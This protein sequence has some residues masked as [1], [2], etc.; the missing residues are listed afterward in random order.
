MAQ[1][2]AVG[3]RTVDEAYGNYPAVKNESAASGVSWAAVAAGAFVTAAFS[4][5]L[6]ALGAGAGL[7]SLSPWGSSGVSPETVG[8][9]ALVWL[10]IVEI[11]AAALGGYVAGRLRTKWVDTHTDEV[12]FR[13]TAHGLLT[14]AVALVI[15]AAFLGSAATRMVGNESRAEG[16][17]ASGVGRSEGPAMEANRYYVDSLFRSS[18]PAAANEVALRT[19]VGAI[20]AHAIAQ[21]DFSDADKQY[22]T[23]RVAATTGL[24]PAQASQR[25]DSVF[26]QDRQAADAARKAVAHALYWLF[27]ALLL[28]AFSGSFAATFGGRQRDRIRA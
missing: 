24:S 8:K 3:T 6:L 25:V 11:I 18:A 15:T 27:V 7:S 21:R 14:W 5:I 2:A 23:A 17:A 13:D 16:S 19:E 1:V 22:V 12:Y 28:G 9:G 10:A 20:F 4:L 26:E